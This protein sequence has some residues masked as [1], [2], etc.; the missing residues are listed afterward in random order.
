MKY[1]ILTL[2]F[3]CVLWTGCKKDGDSNR[4]PPEPAPERSE[5][6]ATTS[7]PPPPEPMPAEL[8]EAIEDIL[9]LE[10]KA[11]F[12]QALRE[13]QE[14]RPHVEAAEHQKEVQTIINRLVEEE[15]AA[16]ELEYARENL[17]SSNSSERRVARQ[18]FVDAGE[19]GR[20]ILRRVFQTSDNPAEKEA[21]VEILRD[22]GNAEDARVFLFALRGA[23]LPA[24]R[25]R[26]YQTVQ[27][28]I[29]KNSSSMNEKLLIDEIL[30]YGTGLSD[31]DESARFRVLGRHW[32]FPK[33]S[34]RRLDARFTQVA[35]DD[36]FSKRHIVE[37]L[38]LVYRNKA[39]SDALHFEDMF[40]NGAGNLGTLRKYVRKAKASGKPGLVRWAMELQ[41]LLGSGKLSI[42]GGRIEFYFPMTDSKAS[43]DKSG[44][45]N[46]GTNHRFDLNPVA[47]VLNQCLTFT[48]DQHIDVPSRNVMNAHDDSYTYS[49]WVNPEVLPK[50]K[51]PDPYYMLMGRPQPHSGLVITRRGTPAFQYTVIGKKASKEVACE[52]IRRLKPG[53][54]THLVVVVDRL[55]NEVRLYVNGDSKDRLQ[56]RRHWRIGPRKTLLRIG[57]ASPQSDRNKCRFRGKLDE[58]IF[59]SRALDE[60]EIKTLYYLP[61][62]RQYYQQGL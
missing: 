9:E 24:R 59:Y 3:G 55:K 47:G 54:W 46:D 43:T 19:A 39:G 30:K 10:R 29:D 28:L 35:N 25:R 18:Q 8:K 26:L 5:D 52:S 62:V 60:H 14:I 34:P 53:Q 48:G 45:G 37:Y 13:A 49:L 41:L 61:K 4:P 15:S 57:A 27:I 23:T 22:I 42:P 20:I 58:V 11:R 16:A 12:S 33:L 1:C 36:N 17:A 44:H 51:Q 38:G 40:T 56:I 21:A 6:G 7:L 32:N 2:L 50:H 31:P